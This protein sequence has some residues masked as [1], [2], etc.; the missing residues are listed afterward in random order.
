[1]SCDADLL[2]ICVDWITWT[3][4]LYFQDVGA[5]CLPLHPC[6]IIV[7]GES[8]TA[9]ECPFKICTWNFLGDVLIGSEA[10]V[11]VANDRRERSHSNAEALFYRI[12]GMV[13]SISILDRS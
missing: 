2:L 4:C 3:V 9:A 8:A 7:S 11:D 12:G 13:V 6:S 5:W 1:G 10:G